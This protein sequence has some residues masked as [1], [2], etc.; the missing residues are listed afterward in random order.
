MKADDSNQVYIYMLRY[1]V[2]T[3]Y[4]KI[5]N[6]IYY[7]QNLSM[8]PKAKEYLPILT[9]PLEHLTLLSDESPC[10]LRPER[11][12]RK[13]RDFLLYLTVLPDD[14]SSKYP[15]LRELGKQVEKA[16]SNGQKDWYHSFQPYTQNTWKEFHA[17]FSDCLTGFTTCLKTLADISSKK[18]ENQMNEFKENITLVVMYGICLRPLIQSWGFQSHLKFI[19]SSHRR[20][21]T[22]QTPISALDD[23]RKVLDEPDKV[24]EVVDENDIQEQEIQPLET[25]PSIPVL[26]KPQR[27]WLKLITVE[28]DSANILLQQFVGEYE[29]KVD[30]SIKVV[31]PSYVIDQTLSWT[32]LFTT[33]DYILDTGLGLKNEEILRYLTNVADAHPRSEKWLK[34]L[35]IHFEAGKRQ[36]M[37][38]VIDKEDQVQVYQKE[39]SLSKEDRSWW[40][41]WVNSPVPGSVPDAP[42][43]LLPDWPPILAAISTVLSQS[44]LPEGPLTDDDKGFISNKMALLDRSH[45]FFGKVVGT[46]DGRFKGRIHCEACLASLISPSATALIKEDVNY[47]DVLNLTRVGDG[48]LACFHHHYEPN[49]L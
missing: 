45:R 29:Q 5:C 26:G 27:D 11:E 32:P 46:N 39:Q 7:A 9:T 24:P 16:K 20:T 42:L 10:W 25:D 49:Y 30:I 21:P 14:W 40:R 33:N 12:A 38:N 1:V 4:L 47:I 8:R 37:R 43:S 28:F 34:T 19:I 48:G 17:L 2:A 6:R 31:T 15:V 35:K 22:T 23:E 36:E 44:P 41:V 18:T 3:V 13:D